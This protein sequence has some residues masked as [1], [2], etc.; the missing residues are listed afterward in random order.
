MRWCHRWCRCLRRCQRWRIDAGVGAGLVVS[1]DAQALVSSL[2]SW[3]WCLWWRVGAGLV[4]GVEGIF[5]SYR[6]L[7]KKIFPRAPAGLPR[8][9]SSLQLQQFLNGV[10]HRT[11]VSAQS[12]NQGISSSP[13]A[14]CKV[15]FPKIMRK[16]DVFF[17]WSFFCMNFFC[18]KFFVWRFFCMKIVCMKF[19]SFFRTVSSF[20]HAREIMSL[21]NLFRNFWNEEFLDESVY[22]R[23]LLKKSTNCTSQIRTWSTFLYTA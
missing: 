9:Y 20:S 22:D 14:C 8:E 6:Q 16:P 17:T 1:V 21:K 7:E 4:V 11:Q 13:I 18:M 15:N 12:S 19:F 23:N 3:C 10:S 5:F 2:T